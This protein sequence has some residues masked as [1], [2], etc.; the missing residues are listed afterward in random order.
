MAKVLSYTLSI[1]GDETTT[2]EFDGSLG[3]LSAALGTAKGQINT[4]ITNKM[5]SNGSAASQTGQFSAQEY[6]D[7]D[8]TTQAHPIFIPVSRNNCV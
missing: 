6:P 2:V 5:S 3:A 8:G 7:P 1:G 4:E